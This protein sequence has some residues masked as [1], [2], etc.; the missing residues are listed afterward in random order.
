MVPLSTCTWSA[1]GGALFKTS[2]CSIRA[3]LNP[4]T[5]GNRRPRA[6]ALAVILSS[7]MSLE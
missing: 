2:S 4:D 3:E 7:P 6:M 5:L 1:D